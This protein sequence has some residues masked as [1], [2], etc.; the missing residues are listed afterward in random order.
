MIVVQRFS[1]ILPL[2][3]WSFVKQ[4]QWERWRASGNWCLD[5][6]TGVASVGVRQNDAL[7]KF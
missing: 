4:E 7:E 2:H 6:S 3:Q 1:Y 5:P